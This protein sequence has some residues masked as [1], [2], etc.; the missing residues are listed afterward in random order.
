MK[1]HKK[2]LFT[3]KQLLNY[4]KKVKKFSKI[5][6][7]IL[8]TITYKYV[9]QKIKK[10]DFLIGFPYRVNRETE[11]ANSPLIA[12]NIAEFLKSNSEEDSPIDSILIDPENDRS[13]HV[14][15]LQIK[16]L[17]KGKYRQTD[18]DSFIKFLKEKSNYEESKISL[19]IYIQGEFS[20]DLKKI[21]SWLS[22]NPFPFAEVVLMR[23]NVI[24]GDTEYRQLKPSK[25]NIPRRLII[26]R[27]EIMREF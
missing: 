16:F 6:E 24:T 19:I 18:T 22:T 17:G 20:V 14:R 3:S 5:D 12:D 10:K 21:I 4:L 11:I 15:P 1:I 27:K 8:A 9:Y 26:P 23:C 7:E 13:A 25:N 2:L